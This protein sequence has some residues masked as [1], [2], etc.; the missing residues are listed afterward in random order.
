M[1]AWPRAP[2]SAASACWTVRGRALSAGPSLVSRPTPQGGAC[3]L[4]EPPASSPSCEN[5]LLLILSPP[6]LEFIETNLGAQPYAPLLVLLPFAGAY[7]RVLNAG[8]RRMARMGLVMVTAA[9]N[10]RDDACLYSPA[11]EPE[12]WAGWVHP[13]MG[14]YRHLPRL[15]HSSMKSAEWAGAAQP[16]PPTSPFVTTP[17]GHHGRCHQQRRP[18]RLHWHPGHQLWSLRGPVRPGGWHHWCLQWLQHLLHGAEWDIAGGRARGRQAGLQAGGQGWLAGAG[19]LSMQ[20]QGIK[21]PCAGDGFVCPSWHVWLICVLPPAE[22][23]HIPCV[24]IMGCSDSSRAALKLRCLWQSCVG[25][26]VAP[27]S[28]RGPLGSPQVSLPCCSVPSLS[29]ALPSSGSASCTLP[30]RMSWTWRGSLRSIGSRR[31]TGWLGSLPGWAQVKTSAARWVPSRALP[32]SAERSCLGESMGW[33]QDVS[34]PKPGMAEPECGCSHAEGGGETCQPLAAWSAPRALGAGCGSG[35]WVLLWALQWV[36]SPLLT[37]P[38]WLQTSSCTA[39]R[40]GRRAPGSPGM[41]RPWLAAPATRRCS[42]APAS[43]TA[44]GGWGST[45]RWAGCAETKELPPGCPLASEGCP[46]AAL[47]TML[48]CLGRRTRT[49]RSSVWPTTLSGVGVSQPSPGAARGPGPSAGSTPAPWRPRGPAAPR[50]TTCWPVTLAPDGGLQCWWLRV[51]LPGELWEPGLK[52]WLWVLG[53]Q[54]RGTPG[55]CVEAGKVH[56]SVGKSLSARVC[57][58]VLSRLSRADSPAPLGRVQF[59]LP[60]CGTGW[61]WQTCPS[62]SERAQPLRQQDR[63]GGARLVLPRGQ[64]RV[65]GEGAHVLGLCG[66]GRGGVLTSAHPSVALMGVRLALVSHCDCSP[67]PSLRWHVPPIQLES[68]CSVWHWSHHPEPWG[69]PGTG[70][71]LLL[72]WPW[73]ATSSPLLGDSVLWWRLDADEL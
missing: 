29:W 10:H 54:G 36:S 56:G 13:G 65:P 40:C 1:P 60:R 11:S 55:V 49:G 46:R 45:W 52:G 71:P 20:A 6:G 23:S 4:P 25:G 42:A 63:G 41:P 58:G 5:V 12:V 67:N 66:E 27:G 35:C 62:V 43:P 57:P 50:G 7:S 69:P 14:T 22:S 44:A 2:T 15:I 39:A 30:P 73:R 3:S 18:A 28:H 59:P 32:F 53:W 68:S 38:A 70:R 17:A 34:I 61:R 51:F 33:Q 37:P 24:R 21:A 48:C 31:P 26:C 8:C 19:L 64:P 72:C 16:I 47:V 9:G